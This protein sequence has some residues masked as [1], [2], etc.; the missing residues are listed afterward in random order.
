MVS[1]DIRFREFI[2]TY[3][4]TIVLMEGWTFLTNHS[5][6][7]LSIA[8]DPAIRLRDVAQNVGITERAA[9]RIV[10]DLIEGGYLTST[11]IGR[12]NRYTVNP[13]RAL[14]HPIERHCRIASLLSLVISDNS[15]APKPFPDGSEDNGD[16]PN[17]I[18]ERIV[19]PAS[20]LSK[21]RIKGRRS[22]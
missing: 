18:Q 5:H 10:A 21:P 6:V 8:S 19:S 14:R 7:L 13:D 15:N 16:T 17:G 11:R 9:Q 22:V 3:C 20:S 1:Y 2:N 12:R 4:V